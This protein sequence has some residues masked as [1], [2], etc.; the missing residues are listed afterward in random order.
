MQAPQ[1][2][3]DK[4]GRP[5][6]PTSAAAAAA[7]RVLL[8]DAAV[9]KIM[10]DCRREVQT[11]LYGHNIPLV[12][13]LD[14]KVLQGYKA[15]LYYQAGSGRSVEESCPDLLHELLELYS[16]ALPPGVCW[17]C[18][19]CRVCRGV[20]ILVSLFC[21]RCC[22]YLLELLPVATT[23]GQLITTH[24]H[25]TPTP[26]NSVKQLPDALQLSLERDST[27]WSK[28]YLRQAAPAM[29]VLGHMTASMVQASREIQRDLQS[30]PYAVGA[31]V[32]F[33]DMLQC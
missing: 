28:L 21:I 3:P 18:R 29:A 15:H 7:L 24:C 27:S 30:F 9:T 23:I 25:A 10:F 33:D 32:V 17:V 8:S 26:T 20:L 22:C 4:K 6:R 13:V 5:Q 12:N 31:A 16:I 2:P 19:A 11:L 14:L 1:P